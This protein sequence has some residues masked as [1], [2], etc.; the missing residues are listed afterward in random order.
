MVLEAA[1]RGDWERVRGEFS[2]LKSRNLVF[3]L[4]DAFILAG[5]NLQQL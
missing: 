3:E 5:D 1:F 4:L 2:D